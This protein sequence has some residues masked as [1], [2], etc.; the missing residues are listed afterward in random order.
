MAVNM[1]YKEITTVG[2][3]RWDSIAQDQYGDAM[4]M[5]IIRDANSDVPS[6]ELLPAGI[7]LR[8][9]ILPN[10]DVQPAAAKVAPWKNN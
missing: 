7:V 3:E 8:V 6:Y 2:G 5:N 4:K 1:D 9:P 10:E